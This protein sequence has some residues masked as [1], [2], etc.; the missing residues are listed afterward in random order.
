[1]KILKYF[2]IAGILAFTTWGGEIWA[3][4]FPDHCEPKVGSTLAVSPTRVR[5]W[6]DGGLEGAFSS[7]R[8]QQ[9]NGHRVDKGDGKVNPDD[10]TLLETTLPTLS[11]GI[12]RV[13]WNVVGV[14]GHRTQG[15]YSFTLK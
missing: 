9:W 5:I 7:I 13:I 11:P 6:F 12:Y 14:D 4:V 3:H 8:V 1:M 2:L 10:K 15:N